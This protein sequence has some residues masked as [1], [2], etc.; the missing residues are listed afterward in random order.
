MNVRTDVSLRAQVE[1]FY[2]RRLKALDFGDASAWADSF[3]ENGTFTTNARPE[4]SQG[5]AA[6]RDEVRTAHTTLV[7]RGA[8]RRHWLGMLSVRERESGE[9]QA[10]F[11][12]LVYEIVLGGATT[13]MA[14]TTGESVLEPFGDDFLVREERIRRDDMIPV[15]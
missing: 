15:R 12:A 11:Y 8:H 7:A 1:D 10:D 13:I 6:I 5:R 9:V 14:T 4:P 3:T 2:V